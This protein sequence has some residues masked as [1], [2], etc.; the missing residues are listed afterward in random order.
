MDAGALGDFLAGVELLGN[1]WRGPGVW[2][3][4]NGRSDTDY[5]DVLMACGVLTSEIGA[6]QGLS[7]QGVAKDMLTR[8]STMFAGDPRS[9]LARLWTG[10]PFLRAGEYHEAIAYAD[11]LLAENGDTVVVLC[12]TRTKAIAVTELG[13]PETALDL[14]NAVQ[15]LVAGA[16]PLLRGKYSLQLGVVFRKLGRIDDAL[17]SYRDATEFFLDANSA[18]YEAAASNN[19]AGIYTDLGQFLTAHITAERAVSL[20]ERIGDK[21]MAAKTWDQIAKIYMAE[22]NFHSA[23]RAARTAVELLSGGD[24]QSWLAEALTTHGTALIQ[25]GLEQAAGQLKKA[26]AICLEI[27]NPHQER[28]SIAALWQ[29]I[30]QV[31]DVVDLVRPLEKFVIEQTLIANDGRIGVAARHLGIT[32]GHVEQRIKSFGLES[33]LR[34]KRKRRKSIIKS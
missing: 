24:R 31:K 4:R 20:F 16:D 8:A 21:P 6:M 19:L 15:P 34:A 30:G 10:T 2:P 7:V 1:D 25:L 29:S 11:T 27:D 13:D 32:H 28:E 5:A 9:Q 26:V 33:L 17:S 22:G 3:V 18:R 14:L 23:E 12:A